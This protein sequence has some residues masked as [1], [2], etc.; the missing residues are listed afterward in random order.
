MTTIEILGWSKERARETAWSAHAR[1]ELKKR[2]RC[3]VKASPAEIRRLARQISDRQLVSL[4]QVFDEAVVGI[5]QILES[6]GADIHVS[7]ENSDTAMLLKI[8]LNDEPVANTVPEPAAVGSLQY[9]TIHAS[10]WQGLG[11]PR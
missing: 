8:V 5:L 3:G 7:L 6:S 1:S 4:Y 2:L 9:G 11:F 10:S